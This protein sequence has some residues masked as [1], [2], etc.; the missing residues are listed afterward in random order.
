[1]IEEAIPVTLKEALIIVGVLFVAAGLV[2]RH[3]A[4][5]NKGLGV[6][7]IIVGILMI[8]AWPLGRMAGLW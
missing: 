1:M 8:V 4:G 7:M 5:V 6:A 2:A 3:A